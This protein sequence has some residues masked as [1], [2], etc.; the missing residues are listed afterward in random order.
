[1]LLS[2]LFLQVLTIFSIRDALSLHR[3]TMDLLKRIIHIY[4]RIKFLMIVLL[5]SPLLINWRITTAFQHQ[6]IPCVEPEC[7]K[8][9]QKEAVCWTF[10]LCLLSVMLQRR[11]A[12]VEKKNIK[13]MT[14]TFPWV[15]TWVSLVCAYTS[16]RERCRVGF[17]L[18]I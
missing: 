1:M 4:L 5:K 15:K 7:S 16:D 10:L 6:R 13:I 9:K 11:V 18:M 12:S 3:L 2:S 14:M 17:S 8:W